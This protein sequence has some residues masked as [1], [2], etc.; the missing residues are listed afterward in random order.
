MRW[1]LRILGVLVG[2]VVLVGL[3][4]ALI[5]TE[6]IAALAAGEF[7]KATGRAL[8]IG[9][10]V[11]PT[12]WPELGVRLGEV[13]VADAPW[14]GPAPMFEAE[15]LAVGV[16]LA[17]LVSG[18][19][20]ITGVEAVA[21]VLRLTR[22]EDGRGNWE[23]APPGGA[24]AAA[25]VAGAA[26]P[27]ADAPADAPAAARRPFSLDRAT[28]AGG[29]VIYRDDAAGQ[30]F[31]LTDLAL[32]TAIP[33]LD[34]P[35][36][37]TVSGRLNGAPLTARIDLARLSDVLAGR[38]SGIG[39]DVALA[40]AT[41]RF[42]GRAGGT[43]TSVEGRIALAAEGL[44]APFAALG[45]PAPDLPRGAGRDRL[46]LDA[47][48]TL[49]A[50]GTLYLRDMVL[51]LDDNRIAGAVDLATGGDRPRLTADLAAGALSL[52]AAAESPAAGG[53]GGSGGGAGGGWSTA[54][55][56]VS[57]LGLLDATVALTAEGIDADPVALGRTA[58]LARLDDRRLV[59]EIADL[60][61]Y[62]GRITGEAFV[63]GR[64]GLSAS[65][66][67]DASG[68]A[69]QPLLSAFAGTDRLLA[70]ADGRVRLL[71]SGASVDALVRR[72]SGE[73]R[74]ALGE[75]ELRGLDIAGMIRNL[76][77]GYVGEGQKT[78][79]DSVTARVT[80]AD[81]V[82]RNDDLAFTAPLLTAAGRGTVDLGRQSL[83]YRLTPRAL[84]GADGT[85]GVMVPVT[86]AGPWAD[87]RI[88]LDLESLAEQ[89]LKIEEEKIRARAE[90]ELQR[91]A[92]DL[93]I[94]PEA[95]ESLQD[96][97]KRKLEERAEEVLKREGDKLLR[98]LLGGN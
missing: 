47:G 90:A 70:A 89:R 77:P 95:D 42:E 25:P 41:A 27:V 19:V 3:A 36:S 97:A 82:L 92:E 98:G 67:L 22:A 85:G 32:E 83:D 46:S 39:A 44:A 62:G 2:L 84:P 7:R 68:I 94:T 33:A 87:P 79:F 88:A 1:V 35:V 71:S 38:V 55:I 30:V 12:V 26:A 5:P 61:A 59:I 16:D 31:D 72:L 50:A 34:G 52:P 43:P 64:G 93:G 66:D 15:A 20:R 28:V 24:G 56:D 65:A 76:D 49:D 48:L 63:N 81:G 58:L 57:A 86:I 60:R 21:P 91:Q 51:T 18:E 69:L 37:A 6:R 8:T 74:I 4:V 10:S 75:G 40:G 78:I 14:A 11:R 54:P 45:L 53:G 23:V 17:A 73:G 29:R 96:A 80:I 9:G 13:A